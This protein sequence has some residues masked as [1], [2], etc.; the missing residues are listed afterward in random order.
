MSHLFGILFSPRSA[1]ESIRDVDGFILITYLKFAIPIALLPVL[2]WYYGYV[3]IGWEFGDRV[4]R[5][6]STSAN[7]I[8]SLF[9]LAMLIGTGLLG[10]MVHWMSEIYEASPST[11]SKG[12]RIAAYTLAPLFVCG[13]TGLYSVLWLDILLGCAAAGYAVYLLYIGVPIVMRVP[14]ERGFL[15]ASAMVAVGLVGCAAMLGATV[16]LWEMGAMPVF[17]D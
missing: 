14:A 16:I 11:Y 15:F 13:A 8:M 1:W 17:K 9:Y 3:Q 6:T 12:V 2:A 5:L 10:F 4:I 7:Q